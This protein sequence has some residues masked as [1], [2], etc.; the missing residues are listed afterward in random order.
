MSD[1]R[2]LDAT[3][4]TQGPGKNHPILRRPEDVPSTRAAQVLEMR[5]LPQGIEELW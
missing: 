1:Q 4:A 3:L 2:L 5:V